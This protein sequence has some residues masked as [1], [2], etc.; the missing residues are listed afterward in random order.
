[1]GQGLIG[2][3]KRAYLNNKPEC[4]AA[5]ELCK[6]IIDAMDVCSNGEAA[7]FT[8]MNFG[9]FTLFT[10][11]FTAVGRVMETISRIL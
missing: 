9:K 5:L 4:T 7:R 6:R 11:L 8:P 1:M 10:P 3:Q 2:A